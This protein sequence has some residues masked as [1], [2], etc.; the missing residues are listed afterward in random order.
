MKRAF[1]RTENYGR[2]LEAVSAVEQRGAREAG[3]ILVHGRPGDGKSQTIA[4]WAATRTD[5]AVYLR[6]NVDWTPR[7]FLIELAKAL[8]VDQSGTSE[9]LFERLLGVLEEIPLV[10]DE[11]ENTLPQGAHVLEKIR[12]FSDRSGNIVVLIGMEAIQAR[13]A[14]H[15]QIASRIARVVQFTPSTVEDVIVACSRLGDVKIAD[16]LAAEI[17]RQTKGRMR[18]VLNAI[19]TVE[20]IAQANSAKAVC[21]ADMAGQELTYDW[22]A[23]RSRITGGG[24]GNGGSR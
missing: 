10:I 15:Q 22:Q 9:R 1:V 16:D 7:Y 4:H 14:R 18:E 6:A 23:L 17:H 24:N 5:G 20:R 2:F 12:D 11:A 13:I 3:M 19:A 8:K 21:L